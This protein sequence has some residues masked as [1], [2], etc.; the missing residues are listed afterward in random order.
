MDPHGVGNYNRIC[1]YQRIE[2]DSFSRQKTERVAYSII[3]EPPKESWP[4]RKPLIWPTDTVATLQQPEFGLQQ[5]DAVVTIRPSALLQ[6]CQRA[7]SAPHKS[8]IF[9]EG[10]RIMLD[11][12]TR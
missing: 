11:L 4:E 2:F 6:I 3:L 5:N 1:H 9:P 7:G 12:S 10:D 8:L